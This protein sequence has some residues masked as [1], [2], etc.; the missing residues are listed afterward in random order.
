MANELYS[1]SVLFTYFFRELSYFSATTSFLSRIASASM[2]SPI[3]P[4]QPARVN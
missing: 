3:L 4:C 2:P 1:L